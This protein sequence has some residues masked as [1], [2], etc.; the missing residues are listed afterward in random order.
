MQRCLPI[1]L[2]CLCAGCFNPSA[3]KVSSDESDGA[4]P[5]APGAAPQ[6]NAP[7]AAQGP[8]F[9]DVKARVVDKQVAMAE[10]PNLRETENGINAMDPIS[11]ASQSYFAL[12]S[13]VHLLNFKHQIDIFQAQ[14]ERYPTFDEFA[15]MMQVNQVEYKGLKPWQMYAYDSS[16]GT[17]CILEDLDV[18]RAR[19]EAAGIEYEE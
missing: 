5:A 3:F 16:D 1:V 12:G 17:V 6:N 11:S 15:D 7:P 8:A 14:Y 18:K 10:N 13:R 19:Y 4:K 2:C 9:P